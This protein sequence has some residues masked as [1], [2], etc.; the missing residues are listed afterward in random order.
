MKLLI[1]CLLDDRSLTLK[2][3]RGSSHHFD[4]YIL[5]GTEHEF[6]NFINV[7]L[8]F[9]YLLFSDDFF[10]SSEQWPAW[11]LNRVFY[12]RI[13]GGVAIAWRKAL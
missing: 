4:L 5:F 7:N 2:S 12:R 6:I 13:I 8:C 3:P 10:S 1:F 11:I 9:Y